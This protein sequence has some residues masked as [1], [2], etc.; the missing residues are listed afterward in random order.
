MAITQIF[1]VVL[2]GTYLGQKCRNVWNYSGDDTEI[3]IKPSYALAS[4]LGFIYSDLVSSYPTDTLFD[5]IRDCLVD[6]YV[7]KFINVRDIFS[8]VDFIE[9]PFVHP[10]GGRDTETPAPSVNALGY[11][12]NRTRRNVGRGFKRF[13]GISTASMGSGNDM[14]GTFL[15][16]FAIPLADQMSSN[17]VYD[18]GGTLKT[19]KPIVCGK[20]KYEIPPTPSGKFA[21]KYFPDLE[22]Q[23][24]HTALD[25]TWEEYNGTRTQ[26]SR[27]AGRGE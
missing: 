24:E 5:R 27:Q 26:G 15:T 23:L 13:A 7:F 18:D 19:F 17:A 12:T 9:L 21:Y 6:D 3:S 11:R 2:G 14:L 22:T 20:L 25:V 8:E 10:A 16:N 4:A 1:E